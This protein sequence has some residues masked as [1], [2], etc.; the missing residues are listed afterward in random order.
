MIREKA[1]RFGSSASLVG[2]VSEAEP[3]DGGER[4]A[5]L[6]LNAG[7]LHHVGP[8]RLH[9][10]LGRQLA[11]AGFTSLRFD[12]SGIGDSEPRRDTLP[13][14]ESTV[15]EVQEAM[16]H[17]SRT[18]GARQF[19]L[20]GLCSGAD[21]AFRAAKAEPRVVGHVSIDG[22]AYRNFAYYLHYYGPRLL[23]PRSWIAFTRRQLA[24]AGRVVRATLGRGQ[25]SPTAPPV[26]AREFAPRDEVASEL[27]ALANQGV[28]QFFIYTA[29]HERWYNHAGQFH[30]TFR[31]VD[32]HG[33]LRV[34]YFAD[35]DHTFPDLGHQEALITAICDWARSVWSEGLRRETGAEVGGGAVAS[36]GV[37]DR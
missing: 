22:F 34:D 3:V 20:F 12:F 11:A 32:F 2:V 27:S 37:E 8:A 18:R 30:R 26:F 24:K 29:G 5:F 10:A 36:A 14:D 21:A 35:A 15:V 23:K 9:V 4:P 1:I 31:D 7:I 25:N 17:L 6:L 16:D 13:F 19:V 28:H 33:R